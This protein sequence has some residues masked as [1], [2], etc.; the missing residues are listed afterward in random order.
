MA[1]ALAHRHTQ[2][3]LD[4]VHVIGIAH[5]HLEAFGLQVVDPDAAASAA[6]GLVHDSDG[7]CGIDRGR[8]GR[9]GRRRGLPCRRRSAGVFSSACA[10]GGG[11]HS[12][13]QQA[14]GERTVHGLIP[15]QMR[16]VQPATGAS[17]AQAG[18]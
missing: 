12:A 13:Q 5:L 11:K 14:E 2:P 7:Q 4:R 16:A 3:D 9:E 17:M 15:L 1:G 18:T 6:G 10:G 8:A